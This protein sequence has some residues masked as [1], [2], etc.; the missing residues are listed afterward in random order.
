MNCNE[1]TTND[2]CSLPVIVAESL[3]DIVVIIGK[4]LQQLQPGTAPCI[5]LCFLYN[6]RLKPIR[7]A[8]RPAPARAA[9]S[10]VEGLTYMYMRHDVL[11]SWC[12]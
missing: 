6:F 2:K 12:K 8:P 7:A 9:L 4:A 11:I 5:I 1:N 10:G 3:I